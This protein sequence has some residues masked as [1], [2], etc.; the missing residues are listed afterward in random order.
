L[1]YL[2]LIDD[3]FATPEASPTNENF[4]PALQKTVASIPNVP[5]AGIF[6]QKMLPGLERNASHFKTHF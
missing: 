2:A 5:H 1:I 3:A 4:M 6:S